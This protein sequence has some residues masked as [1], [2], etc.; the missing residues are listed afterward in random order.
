MAVCVWIR[1]PDIHALVLTG[2]SMDCHW[3]VKSTDFRLILVKS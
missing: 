1:Q 2:E 3:N